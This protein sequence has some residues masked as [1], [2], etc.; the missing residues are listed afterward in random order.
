LR[1]SRAYPELGLNPRVPIYEQFT[2]NPDA[3]QW[4]SDPGKFE[5]VWP[6]FEP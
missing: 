4:V 3:V 6:A 2:Q 5:R 1:S